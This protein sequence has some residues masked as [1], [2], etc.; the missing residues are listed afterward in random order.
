MVEL[1]TTAYRVLKS[2]AG[3]SPDKVALVW[4]DR[5]LT[6]R[7]MM[8]AVDRT[9]GHLNKLG[10]GY[11][12]AFA[13]YSQNR[14]DF[15]YCYY[16]ASKLGAVFVPINPNMT[17]TEAAYAVKHSDARLLFHDEACA[18]VS[19][20]TL[21]AD[22]CRPIADL[23]AA[24]VA[25]VPDEPR[26]A[27]N[28]DFLIIYTSGSTGAPKAVV[29][30]HAAQVG[31]ADSMSEL[32]SYS[33]GDVAVVALPLGYLYGLSTASAVILQR[34]GEVVIERRFHPGELLDALVRHRATVF[35]G[36][37]TMF[38]MMLEY[39][40]QRNLDIDLSHLRVMI[41]AGSPLSQELKAR[42][43]QR[44]R[45]EVWDYYAMTEA[46]PMFSIY[47]NDKVPLPPGA[48]GKLAPGAAARIVDPQGQ[49]VAPG[50][51]AELYVRAPA[52]MSRYH[53]DPALTVSSMSDGWFKTGDIGFRDA[54][55]YFYIT[56]RLKDVIIRGGANI[57][58]SEVEAVISQHPA[59][60]D[61]AVV[62]APDRLFGE[63]PV[64]YIVRRHGTEVTADELAA[65]A[66]AKLAD[67]KVPRT[68]VFRADLP[69]GKTGKVDKAELK[70][71]AQQNQAE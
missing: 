61:V 45:K 24:A 51:H 19:G 43:T 20:D 63:V 12:V 28:D 2:V 30:D 17:S 15:M 32:W 67:F 9:A 69:L 62:G 40:E 10:I 53:K 60:Q 6:Y 33:D 22:M 48:I 47:Y 11:G 52:T 13:V 29:L 42:F 14:P 46:T 38:A 21:P 65:F 7:E 59:V 50:V 37:P 25:D 49:E 57:A 68:Y 71:M 54:A 3:R 56:G 23:T 44:F 41:C 26:I 35:H 66:A 55:G 34:G 27:A 39:V 16:A 8:S 64:A 1:A 70:R 18:K 31:A 4:N 5:R 36:V 58:P